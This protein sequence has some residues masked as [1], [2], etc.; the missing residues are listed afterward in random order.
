M[1]GTMKDDGDLVNSLLAH[2]EDVQLPADHEKRIREGL[3]ALLAA[4]A[5]P[6]VRVD[7]APRT[8]DAAQ[9]ALRKWLTTGVVAVAAAGGGFAVG[10][11][12]AP[13]ETAPIGHAPPSA[14]ASIEPG[15][16]APSTA[17]P[18][19]ST[20]APAPSASVTAS[21][22]VVAPTGQDAFNREQ[23]L[24]ERARAALVRHDASAAQSALD[25]CDRLFPRSRHAEERD[26]LRIQLLRERGDNDELRTHAKAFLVKYPESMFR[27][28]VEPLAQ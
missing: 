15:S 23:S 24:L 21:H 2:D 1:E 22:V 5:V 19:A 16:T 11:T 13:K 18:V 25:E 9:S 20:V 14:L 4:G 8:V 10:R 12:T 3:G 27:G 17:S 26:Y 7:P 28:R 6:S